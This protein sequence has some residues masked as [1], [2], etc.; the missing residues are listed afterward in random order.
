MT[1]IPAPDQADRST[2]SRH[3]WFQPASYA[4]LAALGILLPGLFCC[5]GLIIEPPCL[6]GVDPV[7]SGD[8]T[9]MV[10]CL[11]A[12]VFFPFALALCTLTSLPVYFLLR[13]RVS[14]YYINWCAALVSFLFGLGFT[15]ASSYFM[16][17]FMCRW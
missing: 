12:P 8:A 3:P 7:D 2:G 13:T 14:E 11:T 5:S 9:A 1:A 10:M 16:S 4:F 6:V 17:W 15:V